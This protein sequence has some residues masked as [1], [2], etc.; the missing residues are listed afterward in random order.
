MFLF[1]MFSGS[2]AAHFP[3]CSLFGLCCDRHQRN[4]TKTGRSIVIMSAEFQAFTSLSA[5]AARV[6]PTQLAR[7]TCGRWTGNYGP[8]Q[9]TYCA[10]IDNAINVPSNLPFCCL[11]LRQ[12]SLVQHLGLLHDALLQRCD[13]ILPLSFLFLQLR[14]QTL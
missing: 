2:V 6:H 10:P 5:I 7:R 12:S 9:V 13:P 14:I 11:H 8:S 4:T 1:K 3:K